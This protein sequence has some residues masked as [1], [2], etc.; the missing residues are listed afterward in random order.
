MVVQSMGGGLELVQAEG[1]QELPSTQERA[2]RAPRSLIGQLVQGQ[3][4]QFHGLRLRS[5]DC[6][7]R[8]VPVPS[9]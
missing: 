2:Q 8:S 7:F 9:Q 1:E 3:A 5:L 6:E 4:V